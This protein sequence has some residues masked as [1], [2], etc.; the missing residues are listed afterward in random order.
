MH[1]YGLNR[2]ELG[3]VHGQK[4]D[5]SRG[6]GGI[7]KA[8]VG[9]NGCLTHLPEKNS[10]YFQIFQKE[11]PPLGLIEEGLIKQSYWRYF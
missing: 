5:R 1:T 8:G 10:K 7:K 3:M 11:N 9:E 2:D 4:A 6:E